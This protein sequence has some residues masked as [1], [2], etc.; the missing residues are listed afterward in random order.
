MQTYEYKTELG[1]TFKV[2]FSSS[3]YPMVKKKH[4]VILEAELQANPYNKDVLATCIFEMHKKAC[5]DHSEETEISLQD[6]TN[7][8]E[9]DEMLY[10]YTMVMLERGS[11]LTNRIST[12]K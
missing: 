5:D 1:K 4:G 8:L 10:I 11:F 7:L 12:V 9:V 3:I 6:V 2:K